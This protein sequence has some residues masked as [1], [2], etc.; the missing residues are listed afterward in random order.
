MKSVLVFF[1]ILSLCASV[2]AAE[3]CS[4]E[5]FELFELTCENQQ[6]GLQVTMEGNSGQELS[7]VKIT[8]K[9]KQFQT[10]SE[11]DVPGTS[12]EEVEEGVFTALVSKEKVYFR[13]IGIPKTFLVKTENLTIPAGAVEINGS[14]SAQLKGSFDLYEDAQE[15]DTNVTCGFRIVTCPREKMDAN[16]R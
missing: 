4:L 6:A 7:D 11:R 8:S 3:Q 5:G 2:Q 10:D 1:G 13:L 9:D 14:F 15:I 16:L 12:F